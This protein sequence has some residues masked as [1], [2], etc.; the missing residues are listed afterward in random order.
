M[1]DAPDGES[2]GF[3]FSEGQAYRPGL[4]TT[5]LPKPLCTTVDLRFAP[6]SDVIQM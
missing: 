6:R 1:L 5:Q 2:V 4:L 3:I